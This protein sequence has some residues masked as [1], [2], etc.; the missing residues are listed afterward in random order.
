MDKKRFNERVSHSE[1][2]TSQDRGWLR[3]MMAK[4]PYS[5][6]VRVLALLADHAFGFDTAEQR[7][8]TALTMCNAQGLNAM[9]ANAKQKAVEQQSFDIL[10]EINTFHEV[11]F[12]TAPK[13]VILSNFLQI[14]TSEGE[15]SVAGDALPAETR[16]KK[17]L[18]ADAS[19]G[20]ET[21][22]VILEKQGKYDKA[23]VIYE[24][25]LT[26]NPEKSS[27]FAPRIER[28]KALINSNK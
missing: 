2:Y 25:L 10:N 24:N 1:S 6:V 20:T 7:R 15:E 23:L 13:S 8:A 14:A 18:K 3:A 17:S 12:K 27:I 28:L 21:L 9:V 22:A 19:L 16:D 26:R 11:S 5:S 4:Y